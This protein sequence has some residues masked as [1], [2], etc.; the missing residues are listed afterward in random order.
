MHVLYGKSAK[1]RIPELN[2]IARWMASWAE[3]E[4]E[5]R[6][7]LF[8]L[9]DFN[10]DRKGDE[11]YQAFT[12]TGLHVPAKLDEVPR[13]IFRQADGG[14]HYDQIAWFTAEKEELLTMELSDA[15]GFDFLQCALTEMTPQEVSWRISDHYPL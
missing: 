15:G 7:N 6:H 4:K 8:V 13:S 5:W 14:K 11:A 3:Q 9:G 12:S 2:G 1:E 10:I